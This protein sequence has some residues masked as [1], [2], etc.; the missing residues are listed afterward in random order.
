LG[1]RGDVALGRRRGR[2]AAELKLAGA[3]GNDARVRE[4]EIGRVSELQGVA[5]MLW[6]Y[7]TGDGKRR[8]WLS[9]VARSGGEGPVRSCGLEKRNAREMKRLS[10]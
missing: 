2:A 7:W 5:V 10:E 8:G 4:N 1:L 6:E 3:V 9:T